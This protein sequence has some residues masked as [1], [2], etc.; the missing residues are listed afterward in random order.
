MLT[1]E[2]LS[3]IDNI[4]E[5]VMEAELSV[6]TAMIN[7][8]DKAIMIMENYNGNDYSSF[9]VF[10]EADELYQ[11][12][13]IG[14]ALD[15]IDSKLQKK[16]GE[17]IVRKILLAL[18]RLIMKLIN[19]IRDK[20][21]KRRLEKCAEDISDIIDGLDDLFDDGDGT[22]QEG[23]F[24]S[25]TKTK[26][27][28][29]DELDSLDSL[30][31]KSSNKSNDQTNEFVN[32]VV[33][34]SNDLQN[35]DVNDKQSIKKLI[36]KIISTISPSRATMEENLKLVKKGIEIIKSVS[37][38]KIHNI[39]THDL[40]KADT[41]EETCKALDDLEDLMDQNEERINSW[42]EDVY[43]RPYGS[44]NH[45]VECFE[46]HEIKKGLKE[47]LYF[48]S[49][50]GQFVVRATNDRAYLDR[51]TMELIN[52]LGE[53]VKKIDEIKF[54]ERTNNTKSKIIKMMNIMSKT[55]VS[56]QKLLMG[57]DSELG[58]VTSAVSK[59]K[60]LFLKL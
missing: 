5:C 7:E 30:G 51:I 9:D 42:L 55:V 2:I 29:L 52:G 16:D 17:S 26:T 23:F 8:Y 3:S 6:L 13:K 58:K 37:T 56:L 11:E 46:K 27:T 24:S 45:I 35:V 14:R 50:I 18:P 59:I 32:K 28:T 43:N 20:F 25:K 34:I 48:L 41:E 57:I 54:S 12:G 15:K 19:F 22:V 31:T 40:E 60:N 10:M 44:I 21:N 1:D 4:D 53:A 39:I 49:G 36:I 33:D 38:D 47:F